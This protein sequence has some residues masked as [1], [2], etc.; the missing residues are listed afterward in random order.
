MGQTN[1]T[2]VSYSSA[3]D[4]G[5]LKCLNV[6]ISVELTNHQSI[7]LERVSRRNKLK[8]LKEMLSAGTFKVIFLCHLRLCVR[9]NVMNFTL[10]CVC[11]LCTM[12]S[13]YRT[14]SGSENTSCLCSDISL[15]GLKQAS[16]NYAVIFK[17]PGLQLVFYS[18]VQIIIF[19][20]KVVYQFIEK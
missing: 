4:I 19:Q 12:L 5:W 3:A 8:H 18:L 13:F 2:I 16:R 9:N 20:K 1:A 10:W 17:N 15:S 7:A 14:H 11:V 6:I